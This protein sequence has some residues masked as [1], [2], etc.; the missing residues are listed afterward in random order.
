VVLGFDP[1]RALRCLPASFGLFF[2]FLISAA[3][4]YSAD[5]LFIRS[6]LGSSAAQ[7]E[8]ETA[9]NFYGVN[10]KTIEV[11]PTDTVAALSAAI[12]RKE[13]VGIVIAVDAL[14][15]SNRNALIQA[16]NRQ[17][18]KNVPLLILGVTPQTDTSLLQ[19]LSGGAV[20][21]STRLDRV[22]EL[23]YTFGDVEGLTR[24]LTNLG[25]PLLTKEVFYLV[26]AD[27]SRVQRII[28]IRNPQSEFPV[29]IKTSAQQREV[30]VACNTSSDV[31]SPDGEARVNTFLR[32]APA[33]MF[34]RYS[35]GEQGWHTLH[36]YANLTIDDPWL[37]QPYGYVDYAS[38]SEQMERH[39]FH[40]TIAFI[41]WNY[42][43]SAPE[44]VALFHKHPDRFSIAI[45]GDNHDHKEFTDY[46]SKPLPVQTADLKQSLARMEKFRALTGIEYDQVMIFPHS[47]PPEKTLEELKTYNYLATVNSNNV[48]QG[49]SVP[50][51]SSFVLRPV[52]L[53]F[54]A[55]ASIARYSIAAP[56]TRAFVAVNEYLDNPLFFYGHSDDFASGIE[57]FNGVADQV[58]KIGA[59]TQ[60]RS[61]G[62][63]V[64]H[65][66]LVRL[67]EDSNYDVMAF[68]NNV[69]LDNVVGRDAT[70][71]L[72]KQE[73]GPQAIKSV[74]VDGQPYAY[75]IENGYLNASVPVPAGSTRCI[76]LEYQNDLELASISASKRSP[77]VYLLREASDF[78]DIYLAKSGIGLA[79][80]RF[81]YD[82]AWTPARFLEIA[83]VFMLICMYVGYRL[84]AFTRS[85]R[86]S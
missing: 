64:K 73:S 38:L 56:V 41:P 22:L 85:K 82:H 63:I 43:R 55:F 44:V 66:Y 71:Y 40:T 60:W 68:A 34:V 52:T 31:S 76:A 10:L 18:H 16:L 69:C 84:R 80:V 61:V 19:A 74:V 70:F 29:F 47:I 12:N 27:N 42:D 49:E 83:L 32:I 62:E 72:Q 50:S 33:M 6:A 57:A 17:A 30:F 28:G 75:H 5:L 78:R 37:R 86:H 81:Y 9:T 48:P 20:S 35:A 23:Q 26:A 24:Q 13:N 79:F 77:V 65:F 8:L 45:H 3:S 1:Q 36:H 4:C 46:R 14:S 15:K 39:R 53:S 7:Q 58:N 21:G 25:I 59:D 2:L 67:R 51:S 54:G 11:N